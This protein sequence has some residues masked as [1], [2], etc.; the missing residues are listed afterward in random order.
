VPGRPPRQSYQ[1]ALTHQGKPSLAGPPDSH[2][3]WRPPAMGVLSAIEGSALCGPAFPQVTHERQGRSNPLF[4]SQISELPTRSAPATSR[5]LGRRIVLRGAGV[6]RQMPRGPPPGGTAA[7]LGVGCQVASR[8]RTR[9]PRQG[10]SRI[11][12]TITLAAPT[13][14]RSGRVLLGAAGCA[15]VAC[16]PVGAETA[17]CL[18]ASVRSPACPGELVGHAGVGGAGRNQDAERD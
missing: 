17:W 14:T 3:S 5:F 9:S 6:D 18:R 8:E 16:W 13:T 12:T 10:F 11:S 1:R 7:V 15:L 4:E 2:P